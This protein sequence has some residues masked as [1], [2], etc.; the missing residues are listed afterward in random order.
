M[1]GPAASDCG[2]TCHVQVGVAKDHKFSFVVPTEDLCKRC[3]ILPHEAV[4]HSPFTEGKCMGAMIRTGRTT[5][6]C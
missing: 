4:M 6:G 3:H 1:H 2:G 5:R